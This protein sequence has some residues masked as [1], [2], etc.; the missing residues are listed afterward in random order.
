MSDLRLEGDDSNLMVSFEDGDVLFSEGEKS[1]C[2][3]ILSSGVVRTFKENG[4]ELIPISRLSDGD[5]VGEDSV[6]SQSNRTLSAICTMPTTAFRIDAN[7]VHKVLKNSSDWIGNIMVTL[8][9][10]LADIY[11]LIEEHRIISDENGVNLELTSEETV[12]FR[13]ILDHYSKY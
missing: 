11:S 7:D 4:R 12:K 5:L 2:F 8:A 10:R 13:K 6:F 1:D 3:Y 9:D